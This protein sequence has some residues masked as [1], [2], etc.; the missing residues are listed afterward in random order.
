MSV[1]MQSIE[2]PV[3]AGRMSHR[4][5]EGLTIDAQVGDLHIWREIIP[6]ETRGE[7]V[8]RLLQQYPELPGVIVNEPGRGVRVISRRR[9]L[10]HMTATKFAGELYM[11]RPVSLLAQRIDRTP[12]MTAGADERIGDTARRALDRHNDEIYEPILVTFPDANPGLLS[13]DLLLRA[14]SQILLL[15]VQEKERLWSEIKTYADTLEATLEEL[16]RT[17]HRLVESEKMASLGLLVAGIAHEINTPI[18]VALTAASHLRDRA[19]SLK[20]SQANGVMRKSDFQ[21]YIDLAVEGTGMVHDNI[22][23][24]ARLIQSFKQVAADQTSGGVRNF[25]LGA[26]LNNLLVGLTPQLKN[27]PQAVR[28]AC[29]DKIPMRSY[30]GPLEQV[31]TSLLTNALTHAYG[32]GQAGT[33]EV[34]AE[35]AAGRVSVSVTDDGVGMSKDVLAK[36]YDPFFTTRRGQGSV[37]L[38]LHL[39]FNTVTKTLRG[40]IDCSSRA[41]A[42]TTFVI[43]MPAAI[44]ADEDTSMS[45]ERS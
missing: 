8:G 13:F 20:D 26:L 36:I 23:Q 17:Q 27:C 29:G 19:Q 24:A 38:G 43:S 16:R 21:H 4:P 37:G 40:H 45:R 3:E 6:P 9:Y 12:T 32:A 7:I 28:V 39:A 41:G 25:E 15:T 18:G 11:H 5:L 31:V 1:P 34:R 22:R 33:V 35:A 14:Q 10:E 42:G 30:P 44:S 2:E